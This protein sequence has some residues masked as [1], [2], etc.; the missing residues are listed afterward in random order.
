[1]QQNLTVK[2]KYII[3]LTYLGI[4][5]IA[6][7]AQQSKKTATVTNSQN[8][9]LKKQPVKDNNCGCDYF[10]LCNWE[11]TKVFAGKTYKGYADEDGNM[12]WYHCENGVVTMKWFETYMPEEVSKTYDPFSDKYTY[13]HYNGPG[14]QITQTRII[15][16]YNLPVGGTWSQ[17]ITENTGLI[18]TYIWKIIEKGLMIEKDGVSYTDVIKVKAWTSVQKQMGMPGTFYYYGKG[19]GFIKEEQEQ[20]KE[21]IQQ[22]LVEIE[23]MLKKEGMITGTIDKELAGKWVLPPSNSNVSDLFMDLNENGTGVIYREA[24][25]QEEKDEEIFQNF[26]N[27]IQGKKTSGKTYLF[28][29][30]DSGLKIILLDD[31][32]RVKNVKTYKI[33]RLV[34][35][36]SKKPAIKIAN[37]TYIALSKKQWQQPVGEAAKDLS[38]NELIGSLKGRIDPSIA[39][40]WKYTHNMG[41]GIKSDI[42]Y[43]FKLDGTFEYFLPNFHST[44]D[45]SKNK[46]YGHW[47]IDGEYI[48]LLRETEKQIERTVFRKKND[49]VSGKPKIVIRFKYKGSELYDDREYE[50]QDNQ[51]PW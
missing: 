8:N 9:F 43:T 4:L 10:P 51:K 27:M 6:G 25:T 30:I 13:H 22:N 17:Q 49:P 34:D 33:T 44:T 21:V 14:Q 36:A 2:L 11:A 18:N 32:L 35:P 42:I 20:Q 40:K 15:L 45:Q 19:K 50:S 7:Y 12:E 39:G 47:R 46:Y 37:D 28:W 29:R 1:M 23:T 41:G 24:S 5:A 26:K 38:A 48:E 16:K 3:P 31:E